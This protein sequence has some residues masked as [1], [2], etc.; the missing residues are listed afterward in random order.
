V[1]LIKKED[2]PGGDLGQGAST[3]KYIYKIRA[4]SKDT[5]KSA[6]IEVVVSMIF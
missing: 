6:N 3:K 4:E 1:T 2:V 5:T